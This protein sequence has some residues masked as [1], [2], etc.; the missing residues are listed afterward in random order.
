VYQRS[1]RER[2]AARVSVLGQFVTHYPR[3]GSG[4][5]CLAHYPRVG[6]CRPNLNFPG[7]GRYPWVSV[8][9]GFA[10]RM[11]LVVG[12]HI[13]LMTFRQ[14]LTSVISLTDNPPPG[15]LSCTQ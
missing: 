5:P 1:G 11:R 4:L 2:K 8:S 12:P 10:C 15:D 7:S 13:A 6:R 14:Q 9:G 3:V